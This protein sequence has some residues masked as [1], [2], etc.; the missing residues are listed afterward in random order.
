MKH[1]LQKRDLTI[2]GAGGGP[3]APPPPI[4]TLYPA[5]LT[6]PL[7]GDT[8]Q[9]SSFSYAEMID[10]ISDGPIE[11]LVNKDGNKVYDE[12]IFEGIYLNDVAI[13]ETSKIKKDK[14]SISFVKDKIK[15]LWRD[16]EDA[17][18]ALIANSRLAKSVSNTDLV[19]LGITNIPNGFT[20][21]SYHPN[22]SI[23]EFIKQTNANFDLISTIERA[24]NSSPIPEES[25]F[26]TVVNI[27]R[28]LIDIDAL[29]FDLNEGGPD[30]KFP[31]NLS[32]SNISNHIYY[33]ISAN[34]LNSFNYFEMP[35]TFL[36]NEV[37]TSSGKKTFLKNKI[38]VFGDSKNIHY[39][40]EFLNIKIFIWS[41]YST[42]SGIKKIGNI[43][44]K[45]F[46]NIYLTQNES[47]L[48]NYNLIQSEFKNGMEFQLPFENF[49]NIE[50]DVEY[51]KELIGP[52]KV[53]NI[54]STT[55]ARYGAGVS[56]IKDI[57]SAESQSFIDLTNETSDDIR[58]VKSWPVEYDAQGNPAII[59]GFKFNYSVFDKTSANRVQQDAIPVTHY[60]TNQNVEEVY[61]T[62]NVQSL[63]DTNHIDLV[64]TSI[65]NKGKQTNEPYIGSKTYGELINPS[66][67]ISTSINTGYLLIVGKNFNDGYVVGGG[68]CFES[69]YQNMQNITSKGDLYYKAISTI[70]GFKSINSSV[71]SILSPTYDLTASSFLSNYIIPNSGDP[72]LTSN[73]KIND[74]LD[75]TLF[76]GKLK[77]LKNDGS[78]FYC[79]GIESRE[80]IVCQNDLNSYTQINGA[81]KTFETIK[82][83]T[84]PSVATTTI[85]VPTKSTSL[86]I[87]P[88]AYDTS[89]TFNKIKLDST[90]KLFI[91][92]F[93][94]YSI[95][96]K[97]LSDRFI[98]GT[99]INDFINWRAI[100]NNYIYDST[101]KQGVIA[102]FT[103]T[104]PYY[105]TFFDFK[106]Y[107]L[108]INASEYPN[109]KR[110]ILDVLFSYP[111]LV[112]SLTSTTNITSIT[113]GTTTL[114]WTGTVSGTWNPYGSTSTSVKNLFL[115]SVIPNLFA[116]GFYKKYLS[117]RSDIWELDPVDN[118]YYFKLSFLENLIEDYVIKYNGSANIL[119]A[120]KNEVINFSTSKA[121]ENLIVNFENGKLL[122]SSSIYSIKYY[123]VSS[124]LATSV[125][126]FSNIFTQDELNYRIYN[127]N[128][129]YLLFPD[130]NY[131][132]NVPDDNDIVLKY[133]LFVN[134]ESGLQT[135]LKNN[136]SL[137]TL[138]KD[139]T[140]LNVKQAITAG[141]RLP[142]VVS[143]EIETGY[144]STENQISLS[145]EQY[146]KYR[147]DI[148]G[149]SSDQSFIDIGRKTY[150]FL[151]SQ[152]LPISRG[153]TEQSLTQINLKKKIYAYVLTKA[154]NGVVTQ[155]KYFISDKKDSIYYFSLLDINTRN[156]F[157]N[158]AN[159][160]STP[161]SLTR[162][163]ETNFFGLKVTDINA[164]SSPSS[165]D[166]FFNLLDD[167]IFSFS[168]EISS[169][170]FSSFIEN[171][172]LN[173]N[174]SIQFLKDKKILKDFQFPVS[175]LI[176][177]KSLNPSLNPTLKTDSFRV[178][179]GTN[180]VQVELFSY[181]FEIYE[182]FE[183]NLNNSS[184]IESYTE[185]PSV[186]FY[187]EYALG[188]KSE[189][190]SYFK[191]RGEY[192]YSTIV[193]YND[194][195]V[196]TNTKLDYYTKSHKLRL[197]I[198]ILDSSI[199]DPDNILKDF[200]YA[201]KFGI[202]DVA[203]GMQPPGGS[204][205]ISSRTY[206]N[207][208]TLGTALSASNIKTA[209]TSVAS[210][211]VFNIA[212]YPN[213]D[214]TSKRDELIEFVNQI[215]PRY[216]QKVI[217][218][219]DLI[220]KAKNITATT[221]INIGHKVITGGVYTKADYL[222]SEI[223]RTN[224][225]TPP[226]KDA[227]NFSLLNSGNK[228][229]IPAA[230]WTLHNIEEDTVSVI[231]PK[232]TIVN[233][234]S[235]LS[236]SL[237]VQYVEL[238]QF[239]Q[240]FD[241]FYKMFIN[242]DANQLYS[243]NKKYP[244]RLSP[245]YFRPGI[246]DASVIFYAG[247]GLTHKAVQLS[248]GFP[249]GTIAKLTETEN[250][251]PLYYNTYNN[252]FKNNVEFDS[253]SNPTKKIKI[254]T[255]KRN[256]SETVLDVAIDLMKSSLLGSDALR[257]DLFP[258]NATENAKTE[259]VWIC[260]ES[261]PPVYVANRG[262]Q[263]VGYNTRLGFKPTKVAPQTLKIAYYEVNLSNFAEKQSSYANDLGTQ[264]I[265]PPPKQQENGDIVRRYVKVTRLS[266]ETMSPLISKK[267]SL[268]KIT[269]VIPQSFSYPFSAMVGTKID[270]R[271]LSQI[272][273]RT[274]DSKL[275]KVLVPSNYFIEDPE[276]GLDV[277]YMSNKIGTK[278]YEG[279]W[280]GSFKLAWTN[281]PAWIMMD[282]LVN[283]RYGL[284]NH[285]E[286]DQVDIWEL[287]K[288]SRWCDGVDDDGN[289][290]G[291]SDSYN[292]VE[293]RHAFNGVIE[294]KSNIFEII[295]QIAS[296][297]RGSVYYMN[298][299]ITFDDDR[300]RP[301]AGEF[302]NSDVKDGL[303]N[304]TNMRKD[305]EYTA[306][307]IA[308]IDA[309]NNYKP[310]I[311]YVEDSDGI[312]K[313][314]IL[315]KEINAF[316]ITSRGQARRFAKHILHHTAKEK[317]NV[318]FTTD[319]KAL[320]FRPGDVIEVHDELLNSYK[321]YGKVLKIED[322]DQ[323]RFK[324]TIDKAINSGIYN[325]T[326]ITLH[327]P[328]L[329]PKKD[330][331]LSLYQ[332]N[333][334][335]INVLK[336]S[337]FKNFIYSYL[338]GF[339]NLPPNDTSYITNQYTVKNMSTNVITTYTEQYSTGGLD[340]AT[341]KSIINASNNG[342][343]SKA[344]GANEI[345]L[346]AYLEIPNFEMCRNSSVSELYPSYCGNIYFKYKTII[347][348][349]TP[350]NPAYGPYLYYNYNK[351]GQNYYQVLTGKSISVCLSYSEEKLTPNSSLGGFWTF[352]FGDSLIKSSILFD[353]TN[354]L[355]KK[356]VNFYEAFNTGLS[357]EF[358]GIK[359]GLNIFYQKSFTF[360]PSQPSLFGDVQF[361]ALQATNT[362]SI[363]YQNI[364]ENER[365]TVESFSIY[366][367]QT[368]SY[369]VI[370]D[371]G[372]VD[373]STEYSEI[374][375]NKTG[376]SGILKE[377]VLSNLDNLFTGSS[378]S[379]SI[380][381][382]DKFLFKINSITENYINEY[383]IMATQ[384]S[385]SKFQEIEEAVSY[386]NIEDTF[387][388][389][390]YYTS[391]NKTYDSDKALRSPIIN[392]I[393]RFTK[394]NGKFGLVIDWEMDYYLINTVKY[395]IYI[396]TPSKQTRNIEILTDYASFNS[397]LNLFR[398]NWN[399]NETSDN[400]LGTYTIFIMAY[401]QEGDIYK[402][403]MEN[404][405]SV[406]IMD[407]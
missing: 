80:S 407:Y 37:K 174:N 70:D 145:S 300:P 214:L 398:Y 302:T 260:D 90:S 98:V 314:G 368:G 136:P 232:F 291:V 241:K 311:E 142:S 127:I 163:N 176:D 144:E 285:I 390:Y 383:N 197:F 222:S 339:Y 194:S 128:Y 326:E 319:I 388:S 293:P 397:N 233:N 187:L 296:V 245:S 322:V 246:N 352:T 29:K 267:I 76:E 119:N 324:I 325:P 157:T 120:E 62:I 270:S 288:I 221:Q 230:F 44:D 240:G 278:I 354:V 200:T 272:P 1:F 399:G 141:T 255:R 329:K 99:K 192:F 295:N 21:E 75:G 215:R 286:S 179:N 376:I 198:R 113:S 347:Y 8:N 206:I 23:Y 32:V 342:I 284:G 180:Y 13:K 231:F 249:N 355:S 357:S 343:F 183:T 248:K 73:F 93:E 394:P 184:L 57:C 166:A 365:P 366:E 204:Y 317:L 16:S 125:A 247:R 154:V 350:A 12:N 123:F 173:L 333:P 234:F 30:L 160:S 210:T 277:R 156:V 359:D 235:E 396:K 170:Q 305:E 167:I 228:F 266:Y 331:M 348:K 86:P 15:E 54:G 161:L 316:G 212:S 71:E 59:S 181:D 392:N 164:V 264:I 196:S 306:L 256:S 237:T 363:S 139:N 50:I 310:S 385:E 386:D 159:P 190:I 372:S 33:S 53:T 102:N 299:L 283:K 261:P 26:L 364:I 48:F 133:T 104:E 312:R 81:G 17:V 382:K 152:K 178:E 391:S 327:V 216:G 193:F 46:N 138:A 162:L 171:K 373:N 345:G 14:I 146:F 61:V 321:N 165:P 344:I 361:D 374:I 208:T 129:T 40:Y 106:A 251:Q 387:N 209:F 74:F 137:N 336:T 362:T 122:G 182:V 67:L 227:V 92:G 140:V 85:P 351:S 185:N 5:V 252:I 105:E 356:D 307:D 18:V 110:Y 148:F 269:E 89:T 384:Y 69:V 281:N 370:L 262:R 112:G 375:L 257:S 9:I 367:Y 134:Q 131:N 371:G 218:V 52:F 49:K 282:L 220:N 195:P 223:F 263:L 381:N 244:G 403:S 153:S 78:L 349:E 239:V 401:V 83:Y 39:R 41:I 254:L 60:I 109:I 28:M 287:Y 84:S 318:S 340:L 27:P 111:K 280:D 88:L 402:S 290:Y 330:D 42:Q 219:D 259:V 279:D 155:T 91:A 77:S 64:S 323:S 55:D 289:Y 116:I 68:R 66:G 189:L 303:F 337:L 130:Q 124:L 404:S 117:E 31:F 58:Y 243:N 107:Q 297:F 271:A 10:L 360:P 335:K 100:F 47:S 149:M 294:E 38:G 94:Y 147:F 236:N 175:F 168:H 377:S 51:N 101:R 217:D 11:G 87:F 2:F 313:R 304:Y 315:K 95:I 172:K 126:E 229:F 309:R 369:N 224:L 3:K 275:K 332:N 79:F 96:K 358:S 169:D 188:S 334:S 292:G 103:G 65:G 114:Y 226:T 405:R 6:P 238:T 203:A 308:F 56:R 121:L 400:E 25:P 274:F 328:V 207:Y 273:N 298:S 158:I 143:F 389:L 45:Y 380:I 211:K 177:S 132:A 276:T 43:L 205:P 320:L 406:T 199:S 338:T 353:T 19:G 4:I 151:K 36:Y 378:Y 118:K 253:A 135:N 341:L 225:I 82:N 24:F 258:V 379:L 265:I 72:I 186:V 35:R 115:T 213:L 63:N 201:R 268:Q 301:P 7:L 250:H 108:K 346:G 20:I 395:K 22:D 97:D 150:S 191:D 202:H 242:S 34:S 393:Y